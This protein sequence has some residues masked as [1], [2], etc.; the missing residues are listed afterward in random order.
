MRKSRSTSG[1]MPETTKDAD[2]AQAPAHPACS[3]INPG[4]CPSVNPPP[5]DAAMMASAVTAPEVASFS[6]DRISSS[7][8]TA[9]TTP[10][11]SVNRK[12]KLASTTV[13]ANTAIMHVAPI[14]NRRG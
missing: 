4:E 3:M 5:A 6:R 12:N 8:Y 14:A 13:L 10:V 11:S 2:N 9:T 1:S 7:W